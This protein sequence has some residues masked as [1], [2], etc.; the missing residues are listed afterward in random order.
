MA[1]PPYIVGIDL[2]TTNCAMAFARAEPAESPEVFDFEIPQL[3]RPG[4]VASA[5]LLPSCLYAAGRHELP[6]DSTALPWGPSPPFIAGA[7]ARWQGAR[8][9]GRLV[10]S[11]K[12]W[13]CHGGVDR[14]A[15]LLPWGAPPEVPKISPVKASSMLLAHLAAAWN[16]AHPADPLGLQEVV[17]TVPASF[18]AVARALTLQAAE[19]AGLSNL[20]LVEEPQAAFH[21]FTAR[22]RANLSD[23]LRHVRRALV[24]DVGGGTTD[25]TL[26]EATASESGLAL[27]RIAVGDHLML[28][29]DNMDAALARQVEVRL[30]AGGRK[31]SAARWALLLQAARDAKELLLGANAPDRCSVAAPPEGSGLLAGALS[32]EIQREEAERLILDGF[33]PRCA[34][35]EAPR[36]AA[37]LALQ[38]LGL[39]YADDPAV[40]RHLAAFLREHAA[41]SGSATPLRFAN[42]PEPSGRVAPP[43]RPDAILFNGGVLKSTRIASRLVEVVSS[44]WPGEPPIPILPQHSLDLAVARGA[45]H[46]G[47]ARRG[48]GLRIGGGSAHAL[49]VG[50]AANKDDAGSRALCV[51]PRG[52]EEGQSVNLTSQPFE[53]TLGRP[54]QFPLFST[55]SDRADLAG[56]IVN[57]DG[58]FRPLPP[59]HTLLDAA[60][61]G[62]AGTASIHLRAKLTEL[63]ALELWCV[64]NRGEAR[65][66]LEFELRGAGAASSAALPVIEAMPPRFEEA[67][68]GILRVFG[69]QSASVDPREAKQL[70]RALEG[71]VGPRA[72][73]RLPLL[74]ELWSTLFASAKA[75]RRSAD[76]ERVFF[77]LVGYGLRPGFGYPVD[78]W[79]CEQTF[80]LFPE[81]VRFTGEQPVW[82]EFWVMWRRIAGGVSETQQREIW[83]YLQPHLAHRVPAARVKETFKPKGPQAEGLDEMVRTAASLEHLEPADKVALGDWIASRLKSPATSA[84]PWA[85]SLGRLGARQPLYAGGQKAV[86]PGQAAQW[87]SLL[88]DAGLPAIDGAA[89]AAAQLSRLTG[90]RARDLD[91]DLR[92]RT[93]DELKKARAP[94]AW[95]QLVSEVVTL[96]ADDEA[97]AL[98]D[99][100]PIGLRIR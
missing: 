76:H 48:L 37:R 45:V 7:F 64:S 31:L 12:S 11:A 39:P 42:P 96:E 34:S 5:P 50:L 89:F 21:D 14:S 77:Q 3:K 16:A 82:R 8:V 85:W 72:D 75:R 33:F 83:K 87:L 63:G 71:V 29:G 80:Q 84:G 98:G 27:K 4:E 93:I 41:A 24:V 58:S 74:R 22:H 9:P 18:D 47:L 43:P 86:E 57:I 67:R 68:Q 26:I 52:C 61:A 17:V 69:R 28:G 19:E 51:I 60:G 79:R 35:D 70:G 36:R 59:I 2:G 100:L 91:D 46:Y 92:A 55:T 94:E 25:F 15:P 88:L 38:E 32:A 81:G 49:Y 1:P 40:T 10:A 6:P 30:L 90:D 44:W 73:W 56:D 54:V 66:R 53:L 20:T 13:L 99:T 97:R 62:R 23:V 65:W 95:I 78:G